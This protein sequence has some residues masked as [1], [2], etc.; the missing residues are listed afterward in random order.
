MERRNFHSQKGSFFV[1]KEIPVHPDHH[2]NKILSQEIKFLDIPAPLISNLTPS[3]ATGSK[4]L[5]SD[6]EQITE[7][8]TTTVLHAKTNNKRFVFLPLSTTKNEIIIALID[9]G[10]E[11][12]L[13][14]EKAAAK[15]K[16]K[17]ES[18]SKMTIEGINSSYSYD[19]KKF[20]IQLKSELPTPVW[21]VHSYP[22][23]DIIIDIPELS[24]EDEK[25]INN[26]F[27]MNTLKNIRQSRNGTSIDAII[28]A[29]QVWNWVNK[30]STTEL[31]SKLTLLGTPMGKCLVPI[32]PTST[33]TSKTI[34]LNSNPSNEIEENAQCMNELLSKQWQLEALGIQTS[35]S[36]EEDKNFDELLIQRCKREVE[37][38]NGI[39]HVSLPYNGKEIHLSDNL[40]V[41]K[42]RLASLWSS[43]IRKPDV[44]ETFTAT[45]AEQE[46]SGIIE[47]CTEGS[48]ESGPFYYIPLQVVERP[49]SNTTKIRIVIDASSHQKN[50][51]SLNDCLYAGPTILQPLL[52]ILLRARLPKFLMTSDLEK[53]FHKVHL[54]ERFRNVTRFLWLKNPENGTTSTNFLIYR[55]ARLPFGVSCSPFLLALTI[56]VYL[57]QKPDEM[58]Q[59]ILENLYVDNLMLASNDETDMQKNYKKLKEVFN[60]MQMNIREFASNSESSMKDIPEIDRAKNSINKLLGLL[61]DTDT[62]ELT[63]KVAP[64]PLERPTKREISS[65]IGA[66]YDPVGLI[67]PILIRVRGFQ[68]SLWESGLDWDE[69]IPEETVETWKE[70]SETFTD[71]K[72]TIPR[73]LI[74]RYDQV[75]CD[76]IVFSDASKNFYSC[77]AY[78]RYEFPDK[79]VQTKLI[80]SKARVK[81]VKGERLT[82][83]RLELLGIVIASNAA[84]TIT[85]ELHSPIRKIEFFSDS[86]IALF[87]IMGDAK[88]KT[89]V[90]NQTQLVKEN[91]KKLNDKDLPTRF[92]HCPTKLNPADIASRGMQMSELKESELWFNG[93]KFLADS[94]E[95]WPIRITANPTVP[96]YLREEI[97]KECHPK[98]NL[99]QGEKE[100]LEN[101]TFQ[102]NSFS[103]GSAE[104]EHSSIVPYHRTNSLPK[105]IGIMTK[106][107][108]FLVKKF[109]K[110]KWNS[111]IISQFAG[112]TDET[113][114]WVCLKNW[115]IVDHY[116]D[117][118]ANLNSTLPTDYKTRIDESGLIRMVRRIS[119]SD[120]PTA[121][122]EPIVLFKEHKLSEMVICEI[123]ENYHH[124][125]A[126]QLVSKV[127]ETF[128]IPR[129]LQKV[130]KILNSCVKCKRANGRP[131]RQAPIAP[132]P[133][134]RVVR[135]IPF[136]HIGVDYMGPIRYHTSEFV[137]AKSWVML[138]TC[139]VTRNVHLELV[140]DNSTPTFL[141]ALRRV[142]GRRGVPTSMTLDNAPSFVLGMTK[143]NEEIRERAQDNEA[144]ISFLAKKEI[145]TRFITPYSPW[146]GGVYERM[147]GIVKQ[148]LFRTV[149]PINL[150]RFELDTMLVEIEGI[151]NSRP[152]S[153]NPNEFDD[154]PVLRPIDLLIPSVRLSVPYDFEA[155]WNAASKKKPS[156]ETTTRNYISSFNEQVEETWKLWT[157]LYLINLKES[158]HKNTNYSATAPKVGQVVLVNQE[159]C[160]RHSW[161][162]AWIVKIH[163]S[164]DGQERT[165][166]LKCKDK[167]I[168]RSLRHLIPLEI[169]DED[170][171]L[172]SENLPKSLKKKKGKATEPPES[173]RAHLGRAAK[174]KIVYPE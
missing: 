104:L 68:Q 52:G 22:N 20:G 143:Q 41:A 162:L 49:D 158:H 111:P 66:T 58:N 67:S 159:N 2:H 141:M 117:A 145:R 106:V 5:T 36:I 154:V 79:S 86:M 156:I 81:P 65:F 13:I 9:S 28:G 155:H 126:I 163:P 71:T 80:Y 29:D 92:H 139:L 48:D 130:R 24:K 82:I 16:L 160:P 123:H 127:R 27:V 34:G 97:L 136:Q 4:K 70:I 107:V 173:W 18:R 174:Q 101:S 55:F 75:S 166:T 84:V 47:R 151:V 12:S 30:T 53:A 45:L 57:E 23:F 91:C 40:P 26:S 61:W 164:S 50:E 87:W 146:M 132:L 133:P 89:Y 51:L 140:Y 157:S 114:R 10:A 165:A 169:I 147:V 138:V 73:Q 115:M 33:T 19:S 63:V 46:A 21:Q 88:L 119:N 69:R 171:G 1:P 83:P 131:F 135:S 124:I 149:D 54:Q 64:P 3:P 120:L 105:L 25:A 39:I 43:L 60:G 109:P 142:F 93:P 128:W 56:M 8:L 37:I 100:N 77:C 74:T 108:K 6:D 125:G 15:L 98:Y 78:L 148:L 32:Q 137:R 31:P 44:L 59:R 94:E 116:A 129:I 168:Q 170:T 152:I 99:H 112:T 72:F 103:N 134:E 62:D 102:I 167:L 172:D 113:V 35:E 153:L 122:K 121:T 7:M 110:R 161:P 42:R 11:C 144:F 76:L 90:F 95:L 150:T 17:A 85:E 96:K 14:S 118:R 38:H